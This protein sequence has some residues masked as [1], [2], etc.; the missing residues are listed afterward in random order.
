MKVKSD[1]SQNDINEISFEESIEITVVMK[2]KSHV[3][4]EHKRSITFKILNKGVIN[5]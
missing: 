1:L 3:H 5:P 2:V 4:I